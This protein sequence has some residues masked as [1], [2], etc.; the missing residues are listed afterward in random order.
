MPQS[1]SRRKKA[2]A[3]AVVL[4]A[5]SL[6][7]VLDF[8]T[9]RKQSDS[10]YHNG[11]MEVREYRG[12]MGVFTVVYSKMRD[13][14]E[15]N[16]LLAARS[17]L[18][19]VEDGDNVD[20]E[21]QPDKEEVGREV[22]APDPEKDET[23]TPVV[24]EE[25]KVA[26]V[27]AMKF[28]PLVRPHRDEFEEDSM[29]EEKRTEENTEEK[30]SPEERLDFQDTNLFRPLQ[31]N[32]ASSPPVPSEPT[33]QIQ[34]VPKHVF[35]SSGPITNAKQQKTAIKKLLQ[36]ESAEALWNLTQ[37]QQLSLEENKKSLQ[38]LVT[39]TYKKH[40]TRDQFRVQ[41]T[42]SWPVPQ[43]TKTDILQEK[44]VED[45]KEYLQE[46]TEWRQVSVVTANQE[47]QEVVLNWLSSA[48]TVAEMSPRNILVLSLSPTLHSL[49]IS[50]KVNSIYVPPSSVINHAG[51]KRI[52]S[53]FNQV[54]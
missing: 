25:T 17:H 52:T 24:S 40:K 41:S 46:I 37:N 11:V 9:L 39:N 51:L 48:V 19:G 31:H 4:S 7:L 33:Q 6:L 34:V 1:L 3:I 50:K 23:K 15:A 30:K 54:G 20:S 36:I 49:L 8:H 35:N 28:R 21:T 13:A 26:P 27:V 42:M 10:G 22:K 53:A 5:L 2:F 18:Y 44:W 47:H 29:F 32:T 38:H 43:F 45:L 12:D 14:S 16:A